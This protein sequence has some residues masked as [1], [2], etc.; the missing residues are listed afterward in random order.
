MVWIIVIGVIVLIVLWFISIYNSLVKL[1]AQYEESFSGMDIFM[2]KRYDLIPNLVETV[3]GYAAHEKDTL[4]AVIS[5]RNNAVNN[6]G[7]ASVEDRL[8]SEG[9]LSG[10]LSRLMVLVEQYPQLK[11]DSQFA[12]LSQQLSGLETDIAQAR[13]YYN[14]TVREFNTKIAVF[15]ASIVAGFGK[16]EKQP[17]FELENPAVERQAPQVSFS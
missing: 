17:Y 5:A 7:N 15:P 13:K 8:K 1:R 6:S 10:A 12:N 9:E 2:K 11:A 16:F 14:G 3:K 4:E